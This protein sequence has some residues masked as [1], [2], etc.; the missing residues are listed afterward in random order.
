MPQIRVIIITINY[1]YGP[2]NVHGV[3]QDGIKKIPV[4]S[5]PSK[6]YTKGKL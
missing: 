5:L 6:N 3:L 4:E 2:I 1:W